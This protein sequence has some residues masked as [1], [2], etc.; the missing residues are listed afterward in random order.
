MPKIKRYKLVIETEIEMEESAANHPTYGITMIA[1]D[2]ANLAM[3]YRSIGA[4]ESHVVSVNE[5]T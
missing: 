1:E 5:I 4:T 2:C 3:Q